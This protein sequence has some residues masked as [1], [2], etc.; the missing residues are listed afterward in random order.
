MFIGRMYIP[1]RGPKYTSCRHLPPLISRFKLDRGRK[2][3]AHKLRVAFKE[4]YV[5]GTP[6]YGPIVHVRAYRHQRV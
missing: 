5:N 6:E 2:L 3:M 4:A 1:Y